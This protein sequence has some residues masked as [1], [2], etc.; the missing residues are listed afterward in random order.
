MDVFAPKNFWGLMFIGV[1]PLTS[2]TSKTSVGEDLLKISP[3]RAQQSRQRKKKQKYKT[4]LR[5]KTLRCLRLQQAAVCSKR[6]RLVNYGTTVQCH[7][8]T[9]YA[10]DHSDVLSS[11]KITNGINKTTR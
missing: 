10:K 3:A 6:C 9:F 4:P 5:H 8:D 1:S 2:N 7:A 11:V